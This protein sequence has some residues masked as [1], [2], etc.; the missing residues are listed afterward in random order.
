MTAPTLISF[1]TANWRYPQF[2]ARLRANCEKLGHPH[3]IE[4]RP[5]LGGWIANTCQKPTFILEK[6][7][8][9]SQPVLWLDVDGSLLSA[10]KPLRSDVDF[11]A[12]RRPKKH[13]WD[14]W[15]WVMLFNPTPSVERLLRLWID[16]VAVYTRGD[17]PAFD[18]VWKRHREEFWAAP[19]PDAYGKN[20]P[21][22]KFRASTS[23][24]KR[25]E[26]K[27]P[28]GER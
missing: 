1:F 17:D 22:V 28:G 12:P 26:R 16:E 20:G 23:R 18:R 19:L 24:Q 25:W 3:A 7:Q 5:D 9:L 15:V 10:P 2:A 8:E 11:M 21:I 6:L 13:P 4:E 27:Q 14:W